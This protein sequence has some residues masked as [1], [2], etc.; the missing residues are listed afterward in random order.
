[1]FLRIRSPASLPEADAGVFGSLSQRAVLAAQHE[2]ASLCQLEVRG[3]VDRQLVGSGQL[4]Q[5]R[6]REG[7][8]VVVDPQAKPT[9]ATEA[10]LP[11]AL[12][13]LSPANLKM[14]A[15]APSKGDSAG[16]SRV[17]P[18]AMA[19]RMAAVCLVACAGWTQPTAT[20]ASATNARVTAGPGRWRRAPRDR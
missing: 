1:M 19:S 5:A 20:G 6:P 2:G 3:V 16:T 10:R 4:G 18:S 9:K 17:A 12:A 8:R 15:F 11:I 13:Q 7:C 14:C